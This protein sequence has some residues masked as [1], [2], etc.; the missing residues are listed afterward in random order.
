MNIG[1]NGKESNPARQSMKTRASSKTLSCPAR[2]TGPKEEDMD[3]DMSIE[4]IQ[5][6]RILR[7]CSCEICNN[8]IKNLVNE[9]KKRKQRTRESA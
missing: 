2:N 3:N 4:A 8:E 7:K 5:L 6:I 1:K 9:E